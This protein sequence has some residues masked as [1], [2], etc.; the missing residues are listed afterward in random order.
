VAATAF[1]PRI[2]PLTCARNSRVAPVRTSIAHERSGARVQSKTGLAP[3][4]RKI[5]RRGRKF[6]RLPLDSTRVAAQARKN[7]SVL[8]RAEISTE[9]VE[10]FWI[11]QA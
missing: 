3:R 10:N 5:F 4:R 2:S 7:F 8:R 1:S 9:A 11:R 6:I